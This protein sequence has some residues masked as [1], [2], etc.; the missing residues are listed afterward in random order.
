[1]RDPLNT[2]PSS[3]KPTPIRISTSNW[4][5]R[6]AK[7]GLTPGSRTVPYALPTPRGPHDP[8]LTRRRLAGCGLAGGGRGGGG[9]G[10]GDAGGGGVG[11]TFEHHDEI[12]RIGLTWR[13]R[14][15]RGG[16]TDQVR[17]QAD[18]CSRPVPP[19][20]VRTRTHHV[21]HVHDD[22]DRVLADPDL[23]CS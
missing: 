11:G 22:G 5:A 15:A 12:R 16:E 4:S 3:A 19:P 13:Y 23:L 8:H 14:P 10:G 21:G 17:V 7:P 2:K 1:M 6:S 9:R 18:R 20:A